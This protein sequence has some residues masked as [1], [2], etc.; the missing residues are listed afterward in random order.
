VAKQ[1]VYPVFWKIFGSSRRVEE[2]LRQQTRVVELS[3]I[4]ANDSSEKPT[5][6]ELWT[7]YQYDESKAEELIQS[8][9]DKTTVKKRG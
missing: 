6:L 7:D 2:A 5:K 4:P 8:Y 3:P 9:W 1:K